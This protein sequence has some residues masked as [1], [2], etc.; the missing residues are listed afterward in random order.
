MLCQRVKVLALIPARGGSKGIPQKNIQ[1][2]G[3]KPLIKYSI[4][5]AKRSNFIDRIIVSTDDKK[6]A[7]ISKLCGAEVPFLRPKKISRDSSP[8]IDFI[9]HALEF[10]G[11]RESYYPDIIIILQPTS[12]FRTTKMI[13]DSVRMLKNSNATCVLSVSRAKK[14]HPFWSFQKKNGFLVP[15]HKDFKKYFRRQL[16]PNLFFPTGAIYTFWFDNLKNYE[17]IYGPKVKPMIIK[18]DIINL[19][20][21]DLFDLFISEMIIRHWKTYVKRLQLVRR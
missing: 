13:D 17:S 1:K 15:F 16:L 9:K 3:G 21:D 2:L 6:I 20:I 4:L 8:G 14:H 7:R 19:D 10:L 11:K 18:D 12:P 5:T